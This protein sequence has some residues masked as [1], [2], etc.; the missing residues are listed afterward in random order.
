MKIF[1]PDPDDVDKLKEF[2]RFGHFVVLRVWRKR[3]VKDLK[4]LCRCSCGMVKEVRV[5]HLCSGA[6]TNCGCVRKLKTSKLKLKHGMASTGA[7]RSWQ[8]MNR[9]CNNPNTPDYPYYGGRGISVCERW[10]DF[11]NFYEDMGA[12][13]EGLTLDRVDPDGDYEPDNCRWA[14]RLEQT[15]NRKVRR[16]H[17]N[18]RG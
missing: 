7:H 4:C 12:R 18:I 16:F 2:D 6:S 14:T 1:T 15:R 5:R 10:K 11:A 17:E 13:P 9:R 8:A 3:L